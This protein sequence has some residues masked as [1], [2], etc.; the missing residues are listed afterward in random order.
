[1]DQPGES[2]PLSTNEGHE[3]RKGTLQKAPRSVSRDPA[4][5]G[6]FSGV[7]NY[8]T[9]EVG[10]FITNATGG[11]IT[12]N[13]GTTSRRVKHTGHDPEMRRRK[14]KRTRDWT[15]SV[16]RE[17]TLEKSHR[18]S[19]ERSKRSPSSADYEL[20][21]EINTL[22]LESIALPKATMPGSLFPRSPSLMPS[23][24]GQCHRTGAE[25]EEESRVS[26]N[27]GFDEN[28][29]GPSSGPVPPTQLSPTSSFR[30]PLVPSVKDAVSKFHTGPDIDPRILLPS[31]PRRK[32]KEREVI[33]ADADDDSWLM[34]PPRSNRHIASDGDTSR[35]IRVKGKERELSA[36]I[37]EH[38]MK[39]KRWERDKESVTGDEYVIREKERDRE[40]IRKL[41]EEIERL[42]E[43][44]RR[45]P[46]PSSPF[47]IP[48]PPP[49][50][51]QPP[52]AI[53]I[54]APSALNN[55]NAPAP[56]AHA[57]AALNHA[58]TPKEVPINPPR[59]GGQPTVGVT[60]DKMAAFLTEMKTVR[61]RKIGSQ[62][63][64]GKSTGN[65]SRRDSFGNDNSR[66]DSF[67]DLNLERS[68]LSISDLRT[69]KEILDIRTQHGPSVG[70]SSAVARELS[71]PSTRSVSSNSEED[72]SGSLHRKRKRM[73]SADEAINHNKSGDLSSQIQKL[74]ESIRNKRRTM[75][76]S[77]S[78]INPTSTFHSAYPFRPL[79]PT[80]SG[81]SQ[82]IVS[83]T[84]F[85]YPS[86]PVSSKV[87]PQGT[88]FSTRVRDSI[89]TDSTSSSNA[90]H[91]LDKQDTFAS[92]STS[93]PADTPSLCSDN[94]AEM[95]AE[96]PEHDNESSTPPS[97][98]P[99]ITARF[100]T[101][102]KYTGEVIDLEVDL[103]DEDDQHDHDT[104]EDQKQSRRRSSPHPSAYLTAKRIPVSPLP[105][106]S[107]KRPKPSAS[108][109]RR[110]RTSTGRAATHPI[111]TTPPSHANLHDL[112]HQDDEDDEDPL[113][114]R[115]TGDEDD[116]VSLS[117]GL[118]Q[119][120]PQRRRSTLDE[121]MRAAHRASLN[122]G[123][124]GE[125]SEDELG[126]GVLVATGA[127]SKNLGF[128]AHGG[129]GGPPVWMG[130]GYV[131]GVGDAE[132][133]QREDHR[134]SSKESGREKSRTRIPIPKSKPPMVMRGR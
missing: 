76:S 103:V 128:L 21:P 13:T 111:P 25:E 80:A 124:Q 131:L 84:S 26:W 109:R 28:E 59:R 37:E 82:S 81:P 77:Y 54:A 51:P 55:S 69:T 12:V 40:R 72:A 29:A 121:E 123:T 113:L 104:S 108:S 8:V 11:V 88:D 85:K 83:Q 5:G 99:G 120:Q 74:R 116:F 98:P 92:S 18:N 67:D 91:N 90:S 2:R 1:M 34:P 24:A 114:L 10:S 70:P 97:T 134:L 20:E 105:N 30:P 64:L 39:E 32:G 78:K 68:R 132:E 52:L 31:P 75:N 133:E 79:P 86:E 3:S 71:W 66:R 96:R 87:V 130:E 94:D 60:A 102:P 53:S 47:P 7:F 9:A 46:A 35:E 63:T 95:D 73:E 50:P 129:A 41:E 122:V 57:R 49:P 27:F 89:S 118:S 19:E 42:K 15:D 107:P 119:R 33:D 17:T 93:A 56:F 43:E 101:P 6:L 112:G 38:K 65:F 117:S 127:R 125:Y 22:K 36:A 106:M 14:K 44:L 16:E 23:E 100:T 62:S 48:P 115:L 58:P 110:T 126:N 4:P 61:L 45:R